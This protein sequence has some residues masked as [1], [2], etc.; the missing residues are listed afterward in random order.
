MDKNNAQAALEAATRVAAAGAVAGNTAWLR[1]Q[2]ILRQA[3][4]FKKWLDENTPA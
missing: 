2:D 4:E 1:Q 3:S